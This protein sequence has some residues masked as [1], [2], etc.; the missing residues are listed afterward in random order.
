MVPSNYVK[1]IAGTRTRT[2]SRERVRVLAKNLIIQF[3]F[4]IK[5]VFLIDSYLI[6]SYSNIKSLIA[7]DAH[8]L[9]RRIATPYRL[10]VI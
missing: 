3:Y 8:Y 4:I 10:V 7:L 6:D 9:L 2:R 5:L 1:F